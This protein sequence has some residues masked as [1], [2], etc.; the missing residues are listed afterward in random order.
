MLISGL[1]FIVAI[2]L[3]GMFYAAHLARQ[4]NQ[5]LLLQVKKKHHG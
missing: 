3:A 5:Q 1:L 4:Y 2:C